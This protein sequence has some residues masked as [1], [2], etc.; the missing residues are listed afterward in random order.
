MLTGSSEIFFEVLSGSGRETDFMTLS[1]I[2]Q[3]SSDIF[4]FTLRDTGVSDWK[5]MRGEVTLE[6]LNP[7]MRELLALLDAPGDDCGTD[8]FWVVRC[9]VELKLARGRVTYHDYTG[10]DGFSSVPVAEHVLEFIETLVKLESTQ[11][12]S[13]KALRK[14]RRLYSFAKVI[15]GLLAIAAGV[16]MFVWMLK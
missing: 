2:P 15:S 7:F 14:K 8:G 12:I 13:W 1:F 16:A 5:R 11:A 4:F 3:F 9:D 6:L 10:Q